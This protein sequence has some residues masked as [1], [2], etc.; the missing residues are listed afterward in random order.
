MHVMRLATAFKSVHKHHGLA[1]SAVWLPVADAEQLSVRLGGEEPRLSWRACK[2]P[3][4]RP[5]A[6]K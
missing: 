2:E 3:S 1:R 5:I 4:A 6:W